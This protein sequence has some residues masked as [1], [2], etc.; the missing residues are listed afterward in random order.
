MSKYAGESKL[1]TNQVADMATSIVRRLL[2][3]G[4]PFTN[5]P[6][7]I[8]LP[9]LY[10]GKRVPFLLAI[11]PDAQNRSPAVVEIDGR[12]GTVVSLHLWDKAFYDVEDLKEIGRRVYT[13][14][15]IV[16]RP[17]TEPQRIGPPLPR[18]STNELNVTIRNYLDFCRKLG[19]PAGSNANLGA[20]N[21]EWTWYFTDD[22]ISVETPVCQVQF[23][24]G[25]GYMVFK[26]TVCG[27][28]TS[29][30]FFVGAWMNRP[31]EQWKPFQGTIVKRWQDLAADFGNLLVAKF[32][33]SRAALDGLTPDT[34]YVVPELGSTGLKRAE[35]VWL[36]KKPTSK[37]FDR[38]IGRVISAI[39]AEFDLETGEL[40]LLRI[41]DLKMIEQ[42]GKSQIKAK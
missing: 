42:V 9:G 33:I 26:G 20:V 28:F 13:P 12:S 23:S 29:N 41:Y 3:K 14:D 40:E 11:F 36:P 35:I 38:R 5:G 16:V 22:W 4:D 32:G 21:W 25:S 24:D 30:A 15:P 39:A 34:E 37:S 19:V 8:V 17:K 27:F 10:Q 18:P 1:T 7:Q 2:K 31:Q 6:P